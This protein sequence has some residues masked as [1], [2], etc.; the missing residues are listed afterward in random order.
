MK[1]SQNNTMLMLLIYII[2]VHMADSYVNIILDNFEIGYPV[3]FE[4]MC[5]TEQDRFNYI[6]GISIAQCVKECSARAHCQ[7]LGFRSRLNVCE[8]FTS[9]NTSHLLPGNCI[10]IAKMN[11]NTIKVSYLL[12]KVLY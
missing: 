1:I 3:R 11:V 4:K 8:L 5:H 9:S 12:S 10:Y 7:A 2:S 6:F